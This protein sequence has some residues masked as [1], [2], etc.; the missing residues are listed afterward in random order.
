VPRPAGFGGARAA[1]GP[2]ARD[3]RPARSAKVYDRA[4]FEKWYRN[5]RIG[6][7]SRQALE[8]KV[9][10]AVAAAEYYLMRPIASVLDVGCG[11]GVWRAPLRRLR[12][13]VEYLGLDSSQYAV[14]RFGRARNL[15]LATFGQLGELR[16][17]RVFD[18]IVCSDVLHY[19]PDAELRRGLRGIAD[20][21][22]GTAFID[23]FTARDDPDGDKVG[24]IARSPR[25]YRAAFSRA[26][27]IAVGSHN[28]VGPRLEGSLAAL[29]HF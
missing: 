2:S 12:P 19:V 5:P 15:R 16:F 7:A 28:Y 21:L 17:D 11:E 25:W 18:L 22:A 26:G 27:L 1:A 4:Y 13:G 3:D 14:A 29:E 24:F 6:V 8:R 20:M 23:L 9:A 10:L